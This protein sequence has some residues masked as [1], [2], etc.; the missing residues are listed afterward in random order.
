MKSLGVMEIFYGQPWSETDRLAYAQF[1]K[2][3]G[4]GFYIYGPKA[5][6]CL[7]KNW[8]LAPSK[9]EL[10]KYRK[11]RDVYHRQG[12]QFGIIL[13]PHGLDGGFDLAARRALQE[14]VKILND[15]GLD[16]FGLFFDDMK[17][18]PD[19]ADKQI[20]I[21]SVASAST[22]AKLIF[23]PS[24]YCYDP[25]LE[26]LF[27]DRPTDY[28]EKLGRELPS[29][30]EILWTGEQIISSEISA[31]HLLAVSDTLRR[32]PFICDNFFADDG[33]MNCN[34][35]KLVPP[36]GRSRDAFS[37]ASGWAFNPMNQAHLSKLV[38]LAT[39][40]HL[41]GGH[42]PIAAFVEAVRTSL[43]PRLAEFIVSNAEVFA[44]GGLEVLPETER[45]KLRDDLAEFATNPY[46][47]EII[48]WLNGDFIVDF[49]AMIEQSCYV[50]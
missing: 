28:L 39:M 13:S 24:F 9:E 2:D 32:K 12:L 15:V 36:T 49:G 43:P 22:N 34:M 5:D 40:K 37:K 41:T 1:L 44:T 50:G 48:R 11:I 20:E 7:R 23:C 47:M 26:M 3:I 30:V 17:S 42:E 19:L 33:P 27:G 21:A 6:E 29:N 18:A 35:L 25:L 46:A 16:Y 14:K 8:R 10:D 38:L 4:M 31:E 45:E